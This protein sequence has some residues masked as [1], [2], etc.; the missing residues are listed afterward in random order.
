MGCAES[1]ALGNDRHQNRRS[2]KPTRQ[3]AS[4]TP[5]HHHQPSSSNNNHSAPPLYTNNRNTL[6][7]ASSRHHHHQ[8]LGSGIVSEE[9]GDD[10][11][12][13]DMYQPT[14]ATLRGR[15]GKQWLQ[16]HAP[17]AHS[18]VIAEP[19]SPPPTP[20]VTTPRAMDT[21]AYKPLSA[22]FLGFSKTELATMAEVN[23]HHQRTGGGGGVH[24][25][26]PQSSL[27]TPDVAS[28][29]L[30]P[31]TSPTPQ[32]Q[33]SSATSSPNHHQAVSRGVS[34]NPADIGGR[35]AKH[36]YAGGGGGRTNSSPSST[37]RSTPGPTNTA[38]TSPNNNSKPPLAPTLHHAA[39]GGAIDFF[40]PTPTDINS[41]GIPTPVQN[42][43]NNN[44]HLHPHNSH[45]STDTGLAAVMATS[46]NSVGGGGGGGGGVLAMSRSGNREVGGI[47]LVPGLPRSVLQSTGTASSAVVS[48]NNNN[49]N[50]A[51]MSGS[52]SKRPSGLFSPPSSLG[53]QRRGRYERIR[54]WLDVIDEDTYHHTSKSPSPQQQQLP[55]VSVWTSS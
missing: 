49:N 37:N 40:I 22:D 12:S 34:W 11:E 26:A 24:H 53:V 41:D 25:Q 33:R 43:N 3:L 51:T 44:T 13:G 46:F 32:Q 50:N 47:P 2:R 21:S 45:R 19:R 31:P 55:A 52:L 39:A 27:T 18:H 42:N 1:L 4:L 54:G 17:P 7:H 5:H 35:T 38:C 9:D 28:N 30:M 8:Q 15:R 48:N 6:K 29:P 23:Q 10:W 20:A 36:L 16:Q 14:V